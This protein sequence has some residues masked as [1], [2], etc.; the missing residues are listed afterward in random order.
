MGEAFLIVTNFLPPVKL[1]IHVDPAII[2]I[3]THLIHYI[4]VFFYQ[5]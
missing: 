2:Y 5:I 4:P 1:W 3:E